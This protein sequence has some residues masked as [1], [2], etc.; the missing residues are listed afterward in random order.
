MWTDALGT[1]DL[2]RT[3]VRPSDGHVCEGI[4]SL[5]DSLRSSLE[6]CILFRLSLGL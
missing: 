6:A 2:S 4:Y 1:G 3:A 5:S